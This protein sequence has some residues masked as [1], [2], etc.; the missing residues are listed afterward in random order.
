M[1][2]LARKRRDWFPGAKFHIT[3]RGIRKSPLFYDDVDRE[4]YLD[5]LAETKQRHPFKLHT[6]CLMTNHI[7]LQ[8]ETIDTPTGI[9]MHYLHNK[10][11][12]YFNKRNDYTGHVF[13]NRYGSEWIDS[14]AYE[15]DVS[16]YIHLNPLKANIVAKLEDYPWSSYRAY[17]LREKNPLVTT[18]QV[19]SYFP[20]S[21]PY[22]YDQYIH[23]GF[24][25]PEFDEKGKFVRKE[26]EK[27]TLLYF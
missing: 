11:A 24:C 18:E 7:H 16:K 8:L 5:L 27:F 6:Y 2:Q 23:A 20:N 9:I 26:Q 3:S 14:A 21:T 22:E 1:I 25:D 13:E 4:Y 12:K 15:L 19:L 17:F 10:Y